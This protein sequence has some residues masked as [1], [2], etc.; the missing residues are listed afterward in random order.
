V[1]GAALDWPE[2][3]AFR[4]SA[5]FAPALREALLRFGL[6]CL[7]RA[8]LTPAELLEMAEMFGAPLH[9]PYQPSIEPGSPVILVVKEPDDHGPN[10][11]GAWHTDT[12]Y[13]DPP[14]LVTVLRAV[15]VPAAGGDTCF[16]SSRAA[17]A[18]LSPAMRELLADLRI[19]HTRDPAAQQSARSVVRI[20]AVERGDV[21]ETAHSCVVELE[22]GGAQG[23][24]FNPTLAT[25]LSGFTAEECRPF[26]RFLTDHVTRPEFGCRLSW[27]EG[28]VALWDNRQVI[29]RAVNDFHGQRRVMWRVATTGWQFR[30]A[31][32]SAQREEVGAR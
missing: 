29:H 11:G 15:E 25:R 26:I 20:G 12:T 17:L 23:M 16:S 9:H 13:L 14:G 21:A 8:E 24:I 6:L 1:V 18:A 30:Q 27:Q 2:T 4:R 10:V 28:D 22:P 31:G 5:D 3:A 32:H 7:R 19:I